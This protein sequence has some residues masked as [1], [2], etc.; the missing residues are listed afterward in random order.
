M[1]LWR[2]FTGVILL[3]AAEASYSVS[4]NAAIK[5]DSPANKSAITS[6]AATEQVAARLVASV[7]AVQPG[8][9]VYLGV[10]QRIIPHWHT[11]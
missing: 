6:S 11:Y 9:E 7:D 1:R 10:N 3:L 5:S 4:A 2:F 8:S